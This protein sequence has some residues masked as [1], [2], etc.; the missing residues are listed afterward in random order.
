MSILA[1][2]PQATYT[3]L[4]Q[5]LARP[6]QTR[7]WLKGTHF[8]VYIICYIGVL[9]IIEWRSEHKIVHHY[10]TACIPTSTII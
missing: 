1:N 3:G 9:T 5:E 7:E 2:L 4:Q 8:K 6:L 10:C